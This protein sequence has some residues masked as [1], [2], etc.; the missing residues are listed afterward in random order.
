MVVVVKHA[1]TGIEALE[2][3]VLINVI[4]TVIIV[5]VVRVQDI[6][7]MVVGIKI[8]NSKEKLQALMKLLED[9]N[10]HNIV[11]ITKITFPKDGRAL[12]WHDGNILQVPAWKLEELSKL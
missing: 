12:V 11:D 10:V 9:D 4:A 8:M 5:P 3:N 7:M 2:Q 6:V 1:V